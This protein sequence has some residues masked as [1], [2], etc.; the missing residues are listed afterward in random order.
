MFWKKKKVFISYAKDKR[1]F[2][3]FLEV[4][5]DDNG[6]DAIRDENEED[7]DGFMEQISKC[8]SAVFLLNTSFFESIYCIYEL[9]TWDASSKKVKAIVTA[10]C[11]I[12]F[13]SEEWFRDRYEKML[14]GEKKLNEQ[15]KEK[16]SG[17]L[18]DF[19]Q[20]YALVRRLAS[21]RIHE[22]SEAKPS[23]SSML[24][25]EYIT[26]RKPKVI[27]PDG[28]LAALGI[29]VHSLDKIPNEDL[30]DDMF[31]FL[32][33]LMR[34]SSFKMS[35]YSEDV[36]GEEEYRYIDYS[37]DSAE[38]GVYLCIKC[39]KLDGTIEKLS[40]FDIV[41]VERNSYASEK[42]I[43]YYLVIRDRDV[44]KDN[45]RGLSSDSDEIKRQR[46]TMLFADGDALEAGF[47]NGVEMVNYV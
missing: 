7:F 41:A 40:V 3:A 37:L 1:Y 14:K 2:A 29:Y 46:C 27:M 5:L 12:P 15:Q 38:L 8:H 32:Y 10:L 18:T 45:I 44:H 42:H 43:K 39:E 28:P 31:S 20:Y 24:I 26:N 25:Y 16:M 36:P 13:Y 35:P 9:L 19:D 22:I 6:I 4:F 33:D 23:Y 17:L 21:K 30:R 34:C 47:A 11:D